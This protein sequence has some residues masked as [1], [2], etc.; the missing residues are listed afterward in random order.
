MGRRRAL[1]VANSDYDN[2]GLSRLRSP[3][4]DA[5]A[6]AEVLSDRRV[7]DFEV[8]VLRDETASVVQERVEDLFLDGA[9]DDVLLLHFSCHGVKS[10][11]G[12]LYFAARNTRPDR[13][14]STAVPAEFV[15]RCMRVSRSRSVVL[16]LDCCYGGAFSEGVAVRAA[17]DAHVLE[18]LPAGRGRAVITAS[19][20]MEYAFEGARLAEEHEVRPSVFTSALVRGL[21]TGEADRDLDGLISLNELYDYVFERVRE[22]NPN[23]T[24]SRDIEMQGELYVARSSRRRIKPAAMPG[25]LAAAVSDP[26]MFTRLGAVAE[27]RSRL[28]SGVLEVAAG[29]HEALTE[30]ARTEI[31]NVAAAARAALRDVAVRPDVREL[32]F[33]GAGSQVVSLGGPPLARACS[34]EVSAD[35]I[36]VAETSAGFEVTVSPPAGHSEGR[37]TFR[38]PAGEAEV[39]VVADVAAA[40][41][42]LE[43]ALLVTQES[44]VSASPAQVEP[45]QLVTAPARPV[46]KLASTAGVL[47]LGA[48]V[49]LFLAI[50]SPYYYDDSLVTTREPVVPYF[51]ALA[52]VALVAGF[53]VLQPRSRPVG[54]GLLIAAGTLAVWGAAFLLGDLGTHAGEG[55]DP[56]FYAAAAG[57]VL[58]VAA[59]VAAV[60]LVRWDPGL[61]VTGPPQLA[62]WW[63]VAVGLAVAGVLFSGVLLPSTDSIYLVV[64]RVT[65][66][67]VPVVPV[68]AGRARPRALSIALV[69]CWA[70]LILSITT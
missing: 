65:A 11:S 16:L 35:W 63:L 67:V 42:F 60:M 15:R 10:E 37:V 12:E 56:G 26:N 58:V 3:A 1:I 17:G 57:V 32:R 2:P 7:S 14:G 20:S 46:D 30:M 9:S 47:G 62:I 43:Q 23:Q 8:D 64:A 40:S 59:A 70:V 36:R 66:F 41:D 28:S 25:D 55:F 50:L 38:G 22:D 24:P 19:N 18:S 54:A 52:V 48:A 27:L 5:V 34:A 53:C 45:V 13:L 61:T 4:A 29:A 44:G 68:L 49:A 21:S 33:G 6:L 69:S 39:V 51:V 31:Q